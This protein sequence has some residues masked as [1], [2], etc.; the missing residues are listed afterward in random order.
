[1]EPKRRRCEATWIP[2]KIG[3]AMSVTRMSGLSL[4]AD[5]MASCPSVARPTTSNPDERNFA[6]LSSISGLS[7]ANMIRGQPIHF[8][9]SLG[10]TRCQM[11]RTVSNRILRSKDWNVNGDLCSTHRLGC[12]EYLPVDQVHSFSHADKAEAVAIHCG[13]NIKACAIIA[14][15]ELNLA[16][17]SEKL[18]LNVLRA[19]VLDRVLQRFLQNP[20]QGERNIL[21]HGGGYAV[22]LKFNAHFLTLGNFSA[23]PLAC[24]DHTEV[25][26]FRRVQS[27]RYCLNIDA[28]VRKS[29]TNS[30][31]PFLKF[32]A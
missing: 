7:S 21:R 9:P 16:R 20:E 10:R 17:R 11:R 6:T 18:H 25:L 1:M 32:A 8:P 12:N 28:S 24:R 14:N 23:K 22:G 29:Q 27:M 31:Q 5:S 26:Q 2:L 15:Y 30:F 3:I 13:I 19:T 4:R